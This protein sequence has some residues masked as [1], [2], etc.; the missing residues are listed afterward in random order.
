MNQSNRDK[1]KEPRARKFWCR[2]DMVRVA[3]GQK[4]P[5][6]GRKDGKI[7]YKAGKSTPKE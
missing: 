7:R 2:C 6:C 1:A 3:A 5:N 4:C